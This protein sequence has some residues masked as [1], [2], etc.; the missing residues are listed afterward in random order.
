MVTKMQ[1]KRGKRTPEEREESSPKSVH[2][3]QR[4]LAKNLKEW[5]H[6][7]PWLETQMKLHEASGLS[8]TTIG[9]ILSCQL[10][11]TIVRVERVAACFGRT[12]GE[13]LQSDSGA[14]INYDAKRY[15]KLPDYEKARIEAFIKHVLQ[16]YAEASTP[17]AT[18]MESLA[19]TVIKATG[20]RPPK[21]TPHI[22]TASKTTK[23]NRAS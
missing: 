4:I 19:D 17:P 16:G 15:S 8:Q 18:P 1:D 7:T 12:A 20:K 6:K 5:M 9:R 14:V 2:E 21:R 3:I 22:T 13:L 23:K 10:A 11:P